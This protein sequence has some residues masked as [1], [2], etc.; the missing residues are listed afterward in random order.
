M[1]EDQTAGPANARWTHIAIPVR[2]LDASIAWWLEWTPLTIIHRRTD[3]D[4]RTAWIGH[5]DQPDNPFVLV[6]IEKTD[7]YESVASTL[8]PLAHI[9]IEMP[10]RRDVDE[11][12]L[13][14]GRAGTLHWPAS[15]LGQPVGYI[16]AVADPDGNIVEFSHNQQVYSAVRK[17]TL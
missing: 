2:N 14:A 15:D 8:A 13:K 3:S 12:A 17:A 1:S 5:D 11:I 4:G 16:C 6:L 7:D 10:H 9:G